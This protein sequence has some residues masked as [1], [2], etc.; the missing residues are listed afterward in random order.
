MR[1][2]MTYQATNISPTT[3][4]PVRI[5][6]KMTRHL[7]PDTSTMAP[8]MDDNT[9]KPPKSGSMAI[10]PIGGAATIATFSNSHKSIFTVCVGYLLLCFTNTKESA[11]NKNTFMNSDG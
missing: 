3:A 9:K 8:V 11:N 1:P 4:S 7:I 2:G 6:V 5:T 10:K